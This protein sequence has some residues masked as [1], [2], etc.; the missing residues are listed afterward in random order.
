[1]YTGMMAQ[2]FLE[3]QRW[4][5]REKTEGIQLSTS[6]NCFSEK[7][8]KLKITSFLKALSRFLGAA[9]E[10]TYYEKWRILGDVLMFPLVFLSEAEYQLGWIESGWKCNFSLKT[11]ITLWKFSDLLC[12][13]YVRGWQ[14]KNGICSQT[15]HFEA[16][17][18]Y[19]L[20]VG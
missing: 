14:K 13:K 18:Y 17:L 7:W 6:G 9:F 19:V 10:I 3:C 5:I 11:E 4:Y 15:G 20:S 2:P 12:P 1:M 8:H 16:Y